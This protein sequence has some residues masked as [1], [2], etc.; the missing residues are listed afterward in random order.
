M[1]LHLG[2]VEAADEVGGAGRGARK[3]RS[4]WVVASEDSCGLLVGGARGRLGGAPV[5]KVVSAGS[6]S[7]RKNVGGTRERRARSFRRAVLEC[8][9]KQRVWAWGL[10]LVGSSKW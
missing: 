10:D 7:G 1:R 3:S 2:W 8:C 6:G 4:C 5:A 9:W